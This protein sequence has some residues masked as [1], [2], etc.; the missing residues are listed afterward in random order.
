MHFLEAVG[1]RCSV[2]KVFLGIW[3]NSQEN[4]CVRVSFLIKFQV[5]RLQLYQKRDWHRGFPVN[6]TKFQRTPIFTEHLR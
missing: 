1:Q 2:K 4:T 3:Q 5:S 6:L